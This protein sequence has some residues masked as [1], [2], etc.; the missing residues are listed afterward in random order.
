MSN[1]FI[2]LWL[3]SFVRFLTNAS[4]IQFIIGG[5]IK[6]LEITQEIMVGMCNGGFGCV[7]SRERSVECGIV[8]LL[9]LTGQVDTGH[10][11]RNVTESS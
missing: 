8:T 2:I 10:R 4:F 3:L 5:L 1:I 7:N 6:R 11:P 9:G